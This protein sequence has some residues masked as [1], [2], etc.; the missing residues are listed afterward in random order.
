MIAGS[1]GGFTK[2]K[3]SDAMGDNKSLALMGIDD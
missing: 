2:G 1:M 3:T